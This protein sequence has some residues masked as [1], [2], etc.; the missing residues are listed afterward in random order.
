V[1]ERIDEVDEDK[2]VVVLEDEG[3]ND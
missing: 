2:E 3:E 1:S